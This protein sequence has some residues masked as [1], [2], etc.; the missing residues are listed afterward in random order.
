MCGVVAYLTGFV[1]EEPGHIAKLVS[2]NLAHARCGHDTQDNATLSILPPPCAQPLAQ[3]S[4]TAVPVA[5]S[6]AERGQILVLLE[7][8]TKWDIAVDVCVAHD[9]VCIH[10]ITAPV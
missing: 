1:A 3:P 4:S 9:L 6:T 5:R 10:L 7:T 8:L 2:I